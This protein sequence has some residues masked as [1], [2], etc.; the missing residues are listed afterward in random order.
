MIKSRVTHLIYLR[1]WSELEDFRDTFEKREM[2]ENYIG[3]AGA[4]TQL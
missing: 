4:R 1:V 3:A 2:Y